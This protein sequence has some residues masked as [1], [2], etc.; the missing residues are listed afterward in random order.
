MRTCAGSSGCAFILANQGVDS[1]R[2]RTWPNLAAAFVLGGLAGLGQAPWSLWWMSLVA[3]AVLAMVLGRAPD[4]MHAAAAGW[5][6]G[7]GYFGVTLFWIIEPFLVDAGRHGGMA[8]CALAGLSGGLALFWALG[9]G[10]A[11]LLGGMRLA[12]LALVVSLSLTEMLRS[13]VLTGFPWGLVAYI[14]TGAAPMQIASLTGPHGLTL[15]TLLATCGCCCAFTAL[16][17]VRAA[18]IAGAIWAAV[19]GLS[20]ALRPGAVPSGDETGPVLRIV[21][22]NA[23]QHLKWDP[24]MTPVFFRRSLELTAAEGEPDLIV[25]PE[26]SVPELLER[27]DGLLAAIS[28]AA[29]GRP[30]IAGIQRRDEYGYRN[31]LVSVGPGGDVKRVYDKYRLVPFGEY[32]PLG[33]LAARFGISAFAARAGF[34]YA[35]GS[36]P[37]LLDL[38]PEL[39]TALPLICYE[40]IFPHG[41]DVGGQR[42]AWLLQITNDAWFGSHSGPYQHLA[43]AQFRAVEQGLPLVRAANTGVSAV[44]DGYGRVVD[45]LPLGKAGHL[46]VRLPPALP[47]TVYSRLGDVPVLV[48]LIVCAGLLA[49]LRARKRD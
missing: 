8:P 13:Y 4:V 28:D 46:D 40:A 24:A 9:F 45:S 31:S 34:G 38:G 37:E 7:A 6:A 12:A 44:I 29:G 39:K 15:L 48:F 30:A 1:L 35:S 36:G 11:R 42:P 19:V 20:F 47:P 10:M 26:T 27:A 32:V 41:M 33:D 14:W 3:L 49:G 25:W 16:P 18:L 23:P 21:Q 43:Q 17:W 2:G 22:P 5:S